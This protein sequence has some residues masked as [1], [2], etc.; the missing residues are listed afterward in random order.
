MAV[1]LPVPAPAP[2]AAAAS[3][4]PTRALQ[5]DAAEQRHD[6]TPRLSK[7]EQRRLQREERRRLLKERR[8]EARIL[9]NE[10]VRARAM[11]RNESRRGGGDR[12]VR[13][14]TEYTYPSESGGS[15]RVIVI[16]RGSLDDDFFRTIR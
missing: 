12:I 3:D 9:R 16:R 7:R 13:R 10:R 4:A 15:R 2:D 6:A 11:A 8:E 14:W 1:P 5:S